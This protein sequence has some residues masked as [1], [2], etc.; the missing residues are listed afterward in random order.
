MELGLGV[1]LS[2]AVSRPLQPPFAPLGTVLCAS[3]ALNDRVIN[4]QRTAGNRRPWMRLPRVPWVFVRNSIFTNRPHCL[5]PRPLKPIFRPLASP[6]ARLVSTELMGKRG[7][8]GSRSSRYVHSPSHIQILGNGTDTGDTCPSILLFFENERYVFNVGEGF[9]R[10]CFQHGVKLSRLSD[11]FLTRMS[12][13][14]AGGLPGMLITMTEFG[15]SGLL[16][17]R[18]GVT[19]HGPRNLS[20]LVEA[21]GSFVS[22]SNV[23][24]RVSEFGKSEELEPL[25][26]NEQV[27]IRPVLLMPEGANEDCGH[28]VKRRRTSD[29]STPENKTSEAP[30]R[31]SSP[32]IVEHVPAACYVCELSESK[33]KFRLEKA[34]ALGIP[35]GPLYGQLQ[36]GV[37]VKTE[38][39]REIQPREVM[40]PSTP[41]PVVLVVDCPTPAHL[42]ALLEAKGLGKYRGADNDGNEPQGALH[43]PRG[44]SRLAADNV[45]GSEGET[46]VNS[47]EGKRAVCVVHLTPAN[48]VKHKVYQKWLNEFPHDT[49][50]HLFV[51]LDASQSSAVLRKS[52][53]VQTKLNYL[54]ELFF[55]LPSTIR[56]PIENSSS[57]FD[58]ELGESH[59]RGRNLLKWTLKPI[60]KMGPNTDDVPKCFSVDEIL[61]ELKEE[62]P[63]AF[64]AIESYKVSLTSTVVHFTYPLWLVFGS[65]ILALVLLTPYQSAH[66]VRAS[67]AEWH[68]FQQL[69]VVFCTW[70]MQYAV[71]VSM[72]GLMHKLAPLV[73]WSLFAE[74]TQVGLHMHSSLS[75][76]PERIPL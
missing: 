64:N 57:E 12:T 40:D 54:D 65:W 50:N 47:L 43:A 42:P 74:Q 14:A 51:N 72:N 11:I 46:V 28:K 15:V 6:A 75:V 29:S 27:V 60:A 62:E 34:R 48:V 4:L 63:D 68:V 76:H 69:S 35:E 38:D 71:I 52:T 26:E 17:G 70:T 37:T 10:Y 32:V 24:L 7:S 23:G 36:R 58:G 31:S 53:A 3:P 9:Q 67:A 49:T 21:I 1:M 44:D 39:G 19:V 13:E 2:S 25:V 5:L 41:G 56:P 18:S 73:I 8:K 59:F 55:P 33:G 66:T 16:T 61:K 22:I 45:Q 30:P 20:M